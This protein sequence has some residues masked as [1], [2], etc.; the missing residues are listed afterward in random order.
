M[1]LLREVFPEDLDDLHAVAAHLNTVNLPDDRAVLEKLIDLSRRSF[2]GQLEVWKRQYMFALF[3][4]EPL[5]GEGAAGAPGG[6]RLIGTS[7]IHAQHG[8]RRAPHIFFDVLSDERYSETLDKHFVHQILRI[9]YNYNGPT[10]IGGL[11]LMPEYRGHELGLGKWLSYVRFLYI[12]R[13]R[14]RF[15]DEVLS[16]LMPPL[17]PDGTSQLWECLGRPFTDM[18]YK[19]ADR[20][21]RTNK[22]FIRTLFPSEPIY[23]CMLPKR[24]QEMIGVVGPETRGVEKMLRRIG[25]QYADR[26]DPFDGGPHFVARTADIT[27]VRAARGARVVPVETVD[28]GRPYGLACVERDRPPHFLA[29][30]TR[31]R[32]EGDE[33]GLAEATRRTLGVAA[34]DEVG[35]L[36]F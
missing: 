13:H 32:I 31:F 19:E 4:G 30:G 7:M 17:E 26:I 23:T 9:G 20:I 2:A 21:S 25:F 16:E 29:T 34:G 3:D 14:D 1:F 33:V 8:T 22:E 10:E 27:L 24:V 6:Q 15:R 12:A 11:I 18:D 36:P 5:S 28:D 35:I